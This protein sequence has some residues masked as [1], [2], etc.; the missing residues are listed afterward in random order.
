MVSFIFAFL[1]LYF[2]YI[3]LK[4]IK[5][6]QEFKLYFDEGF[7]LM[8]KTK[9][10][11]N[12]ILYL[13]YLRVFASFAVIVLHVAAQ[14]WYESPVN[15]LEW[16]VFN[17]F[18][19]MVRWCVP[20]FVMVSGTLFLN[21]VIPVVK[22]YKKYIF[23][24]LIIFLSWSFIYAFIQK[25]SLKEI[26]NNTLNYK[27][28]LWFILMII[29]LYIC[30]PIIKKIIYNNETMS[31][32][33]LVSFIF[34][35]FIPFIVNLANCFGGNYF[36]LI[37]EVIRND[38]NKMDLHLI[39]GFTSYF[40]LGY[41]L[42]NIDMDRKKQ[43]LIYIIGVIGFGVTVIFEALNDFR[44]QEP[45]GIFYGYMSLNVLCEAMAVF[46][47]FKYHIP[48]RDGLNG[49]IKKMSKY[50]LGTY[51]IHVLVIEELDKCL[52]ITTLSFNPLISVVF[53]SS[54]T[55]IISYSISAVLNYIPLVK[56]YIV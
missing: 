39:G 55:F 33:L 8:E 31:Y 40:V 5:D 41:F 18:D 25:G 56:D 43:K 17:F 44:L 29:G 28:H 1:I 49:I 10:K 11:E 34:T 19:G 36:K 46:V 26:I 47:Y 51:L 48:S 21:R 42:D 30:I 2:A 16:Q 4:L 37:A 12:R 6:I 13:D 50:S 22:I 3:Q 7:Y 9:D 32:F 27:Y 24:L 53:I 52:G 35:F 23:R 38:L 45:Q 15:S 14:N 54:V 20:I